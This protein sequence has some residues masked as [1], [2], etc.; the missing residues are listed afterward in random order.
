MNS[1]APKRHIPGPVGIAEC[2]GP[3][4][5]IGPE[6]CDC[7]PLTPQE[8]MELRPL[9]QEQAI[10]ITAYT[11]C[12]MAPMSLVHAEI[13]KRLK[14]STLRSNLPVLHDRIQDAF[15]EDFMKLCPSAAKKEPLRLWE[16]MQAIIDQEVAEHGYDG[17]DSIDPTVV[18]DL[19]EEVRDFIINPKAPPGSLYRADYM[20]EK[21]STEAHAAHEAS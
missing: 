8:L 21:L 14:C 3:C 7:Q 18:A 10:I 16:R 9:T 17:L 15:Y 6:A 5:S 2:G 11:G 20:R 13:E 1:P 12:V 19:I 4:E